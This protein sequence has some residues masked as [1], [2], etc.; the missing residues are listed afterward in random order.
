MA[1]VSPISPVVRRWEWACSTAGI[2]ASAK[3]HAM[4]NLLW[5]AGCPVPKAL[6]NSWCK[7]WAMERGSGCMGQLYVTSHWCKG[8]MGTAHLWC[9][10][11]SSKAHLPLQTLSMEHWSVLGSCAHSYSLLPSCPFRRVP[12]HELW[13]SSSLRWMA[14]RAGSRCWSWVP[15]TDQVSRRTLNWPHTAVIALSRLWVVLPRIWT[16]FVCNYSMTC[17]LILRNSCPHCN[18][19]S[20]PES[21]TVIGRLL[22]ECKV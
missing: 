2:P 4:C 6:R 14:W 16:G 19:F 22:A 13:T 9:P 15:P 10:T 1:V 20:M 12:V 17:T 11:H 8:G 3:L 5:W 18:C 21:N 7:I